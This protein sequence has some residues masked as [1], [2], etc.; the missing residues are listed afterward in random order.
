MGEWENGGMG[1]EAKPSPTLP[2]SHSLCSSFIIHRSV[3][4]RLIVNRKKIIA[5]I[6]MV[7]PLMLATGCWSKFHAGVRHLIHGPRSKSKTSGNP[8]DFYAK[9]VSPR[10]EIQDGAGQ[11][12][13][14]N[15]GEIT[16][17]LAAQYRAEAESNPQDPV[18]RYN[19]GRLY[20]QEGALDQAT[21]E[22]DL[23]A[24]LD[25]QHTS[26]YVMLGRTLRLRSQYDLA[27][28]KLA[29][30]SRLQPGWPAPYI[31]AGIC[32][33]QRGFHEQ[34]RQQY[35][36]ALAVS[37]HD[38]DVYN[39]IGYSFYLEGEYGQAIKQYQRALELAPDDRYANNNIAVAYSL[40]GDF[41]RALAHFS[42][43]LSPSEAHNN[44]GFM[45]LQAGKIK[46]AV[47]HVQEAVRLDPES[48]RALAN[49][50]T[51]LRA[52]GRYEEAEQAHQQLLNVQKK[53]FAKTKLIDPG[54]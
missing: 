16:P 49:L 31:E 18:V 23:A 11:G 6:L 8:A 45:L 7:S 3:E 10:V 1:E 19:L 26:A 2:L 40:K 48:E 35:L 54:R 42:R 13:E 39:N 33:D 53:V 52:A 44:L 47:E 50:T 34:A 32:W 38:P 37:P 21:Y 30:A 24:S 29:I 5:L 46:E 9:H 22:F 51:A 27:L 43:A 15:G 25:S 17:E 20:L 14:D 36:K 4:R 28:A 41:K 12:R